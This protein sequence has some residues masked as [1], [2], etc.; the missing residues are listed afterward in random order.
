[1]VALLESGKELSSQIALEALLEKI[2]AKASELTESPDT[3]IILR[4]EERDGLYVAAATG[5]KAAW[6]QT[7]FGKDSAKAIPIKGSKAGNVLL[8]GKSIIENRVE[9]HFKGVDEET[10]KVTESMVCVPLGS[11]ASA[12]GVMQILNKRSGNYDDHDRVLLEHFASQAAVAIK[13]AQLFKSVIAHSG[14]YT[15]F[16][17][18]DNLVEITND[19]RRPAHLETL[20]ILFA[21]MRGFTQLCQTIGSP[22][23]IQ[24]QL[25]QFMSML[26]QEVILHDGMVNKFLGDG[27]MALFREDNHPERAVKTAFEMV[28]RFREMKIKWNDQ[29]SEQLDFLDIG[30]GIVTGEVT[31]GGIGSETVRDFTAIGSA[32]NLAAALENG[33]RNGKR[34]VVNQVTYNAVKDAVEVEHL[35]DFI[36]KKPGQKV[37]ISHKRYSLKRVHPLRG[38]KIFISHSHQDRQFVENQIVKPLKELGIQTWYAY[39]DVP[40]GSV[41]TAKI[42]EGLTDCTGVVVVVSKNSS[43][44]KWV[45][46]E[47]DLAFSMERMLD[48]IILLRLDKT[49][50]ESVNSLLLALQGI[51]AQVTPNVAKEIVDFVRKFAGSE[52]ADADEEP[53]QPPRRRAAPKRARAGRA[54]V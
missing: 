22:A 37:G 4:H 28:D 36:L 21:D 10:D 31:I 44:S 49:P 30:I 25:N 20:T 15:R 50:P 52:P 42:R 8:T 27:L 12:I 39:S 34:I 35:E 11:G 47:V 46:I 14:F 17:A 6:V 51:D 23:S 3:S 38:Q 13:N 32:V 40:K 41:W 26:T 9:D 18:T 54:S 24:S 48:K 33:A 45:R 1:M 53:V 2:L 29:T 7:T 43:G 19:L 5:D 16:T